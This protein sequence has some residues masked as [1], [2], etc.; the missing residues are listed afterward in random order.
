MPILG[1]LASSIQGSKGT[2]YES[3]ATVTVG[4][5]GQSSVTFSSIPSTYKHLQIR[6]IARCGVSGEVSQGM[7][8]RFNSDS[9]SN[10]SWHV[11]YGIGTTVASGGGTSTSYAYGGYITGP[12]AV[13]SNFA[14]NVI[15]ILDYADTNK[16]KTSRSLVGFDNNGSG[17]LALLSSSWR[18]TS[19]VNSITL[20]VE[21]AGGSFTQ[22]SQFALYGIKG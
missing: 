14:G 20:L 1:I 5:G 19:A 22:Y 11:I 12:N 2:A 9:G 15:D 8:M 21:L 17:N 16:Y 4:S 3:I 13:A 18:N 10:Y 6:A 7:F